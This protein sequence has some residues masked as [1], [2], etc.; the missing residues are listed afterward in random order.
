L[1]SSWQKRD[2]RAAWRPTRVNVQII[3][4]AAALSRIFTAHRRTG[5]LSLITKNTSGTMDF[6]TERSMGDA[7]SRQIEQNPP[8]VR[9][10]SQALP[11]RRVAK[12]ALRRRT[13]DERRRLGIVDHR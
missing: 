4:L 10:F 1:K 9:R 2:P 6:R 12:P 5:L 3:A 7:D 8:A 13:H 11:V